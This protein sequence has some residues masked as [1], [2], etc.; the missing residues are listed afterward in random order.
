MNLDSCPWVDLIYK[1][2]PAAETWQDIF[3]RLKDI[4]LNNPDL[5][6]KK[7]HHETVAPDRLL[8][9]SAWD[10]WQNYQ[11]TAPRTALALQQWWSENT[12]NGR[13]VLILDGLSLRELPAMLQAMQEREISPLA[14]RVTGAEVP[15]DTNQFAQAL[16]VP[17]RGS[18]KD[19]H[20]PASFIWKTDQVYTHVESIPFEDCSTTIPYEQHVLLWHTWLDD[21]IHVHKKAPETVYKAAKRLQEDGFWNLVN[22]LRQGRRLVITSDHGYA[23]ATLFST[24]EK[25]RTASDALRTLFGASRMKPDAQPW[26]HH[27]MPPLV[28][29]A[30]NHHVVIGQ[31][32]W[33]VQGGFPSL[34]HGGLSLLEIA[35]PFVE[36]PPVT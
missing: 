23:D 14:I 29:T 1:N 34:C 13:A 24:E 33:K 6:P 25:E 30:N 21:M 22:R 10:L 16:G 27:T 12:F 28:L 3:D 32:K 17:S 18:L 9:E 20:A 8:A 5:S 26:E 19:N 36:L 15:S 7:L 31:K 35:V 4:V 11:Q 2:R